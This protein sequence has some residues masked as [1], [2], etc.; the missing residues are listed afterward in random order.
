MNA[1]DT[2]LYLGGKSADTN[3]KIA[4]M[5]GKQTVANVSVNDSRG[6]NPTYTH[7]YGLIERDLMQGSEIS[8]HAQG[9]G[10]RAHKRRA[11]VQGQEVR[12][13]V[14]P[15]RTH[16]WQGPRNPG[17]STSSGTAPDG[18]ES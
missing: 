1:C 10:A 3:Q 14:A 12:A 17:P 18:K 16:C 13:F 4:E 7:N 11:G 6:N 8:P 2:M 5:I 15:P 9:R